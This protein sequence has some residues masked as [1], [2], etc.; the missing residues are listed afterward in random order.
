MAQPL[1]LQKWRLA[2]ERYAGLSSTI[3][4][5][6]TLL[7]T[8]SVSAVGG[9]GGGGSGGGAF[10]ETRVAPVRNALGSIGSRYL[11]RKVRQSTRS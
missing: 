6:V 8:V 2:V 11:L 3:S 5:L 1:R 7:Y 10:S 4:P 9:G